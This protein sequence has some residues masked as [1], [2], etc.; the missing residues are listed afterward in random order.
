MISTILPPSFNYGRLGCAMVVFILVQ[1]Q[2]GLRYA[3]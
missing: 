1:S 2:L 3:V